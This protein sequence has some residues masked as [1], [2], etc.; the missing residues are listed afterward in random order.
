MQETVGRF[1]MIVFVVTLLFSV[2]GLFLLPEMVAVQWN[3]NGVSNSLPRWIACWL[4]T[5]VSVLCLGAWRLS[6]AR[7]QTV[8]EA[9]RKFCLF[10]TIAWGIISC[11]GFALHLVLFAAN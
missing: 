2:A 9:D 7:L 5:V 4:P 10:H 8:I 3:E 6:S 11:I 1:Q